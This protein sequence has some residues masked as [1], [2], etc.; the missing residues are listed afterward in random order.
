VRL[1]REIEYVPAE[2]TFIYSKCSQL[3]VQGDAECKN[4]VPFTKSS[5]I[6]IQAE[7]VNAPALT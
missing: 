3:S 5:R 4:T 6:V 2:R 7:L 1:P